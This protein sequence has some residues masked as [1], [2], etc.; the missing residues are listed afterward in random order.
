MKKNTLLK[1]YFDKADNLYVPKPGYQIELDGRRIARIQVCDRKITYI[2][3]SLRFTDDTGVRNWTR[4]D[5]AEFKVFQLTEVA[6][7]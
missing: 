7:G 4:A 1:K 6:L 5:E 2:Y 3:L